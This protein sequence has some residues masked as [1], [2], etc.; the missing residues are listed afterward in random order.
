MFLTKQ[1]FQKGALKSIEKTIELQKKQNCIKA[2]KLMLKSSLAFNRYVR[3]I[4][5]KTWILTKS[6]SGKT[7]S[8]K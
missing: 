3:E 8:S 5:I 1:N 7:K 2:N 6:Q 4:V